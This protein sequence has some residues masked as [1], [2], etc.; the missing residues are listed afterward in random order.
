M[1][2]EAAT[3]GVGGTVAPHGLGLRTR[4]AAEP[5]EVEP[6]DSTGKGEGPPKRPLFS[7]TRVGSEWSGSVR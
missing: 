4:L 2:T 6:V 3:P 7:P 1:S 5:R